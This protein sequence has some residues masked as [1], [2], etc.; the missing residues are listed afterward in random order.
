MDT[1]IQHKFGIDMVN[2]KGQQYKL[3]YVVSVINPKSGQLLQ[4]EFFVQQEAIKWMSDY[5][6][7]FG[8][9]EFYFYILQRY[10]FVQNEELRYVPLQ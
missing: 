9:S 6:R 10:T 7:V 5:C 4:R 1:H 8:I 2:A 3:I